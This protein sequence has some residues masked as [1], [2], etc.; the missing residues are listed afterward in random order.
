MASKT[1]SNDERDVGNLFPCAVLVL[2]CEIEA[3]QDMQY[4]VFWQDFCGQ[5]SSTSQL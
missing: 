3:V 4:M 2:L 5:R 1:S